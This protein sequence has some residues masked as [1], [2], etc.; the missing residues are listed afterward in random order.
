MTTIK[1]AN[2][3]EIIMVDDD[4]M[5]FTIA[6]RYLKK[7]KLKNKLLTFQGGQ[8]FLDYMQ[9]VK[10]GEHRI[11]ALVLL[12]VRMPAM[13]GFETLRRLRADP[14]FEDVP[15][16]M[17]FSNSDLENDVELAS[18]LGADYY[19]VKPQSGDEYVAFLN[20]LA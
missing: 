5:E 20:S 18:E 2:D 16:M 17:M 3:N 14:A 15:I 19:Q 6:E 12:D 9:G 10:S 7:S 13:N 1:I 11:P 4:E 8:P